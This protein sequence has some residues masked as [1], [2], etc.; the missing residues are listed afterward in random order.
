MQETPRR[1]S[2]GGLGV[3]IRGPSLVEYQPHPGEIEGESVVTEELMGDQAADMEAERISENR[4]RSFVHGPRHVSLRNCV[5]TGA[6]RQAVDDNIDGRE[7]AGA[8]HALLGL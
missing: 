5:R 6:Q 2:S 3:A 8:A 7:Q 1:K 4:G